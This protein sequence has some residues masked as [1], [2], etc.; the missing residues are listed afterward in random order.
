M[1]TK[2]V[3]CQKSGTIFIICLCLYIGLSC[4]QHEVK[5]YCIMQAILKFPNLAQ[6]TL[7]FQPTCRW[8]YR[9]STHTHHPTRDN[10]RI[11][12]EI[13]SVHKKTTISL[14]VVTEEEST[15]NLS[16]LLPPTMNL[17]SSGWLKLNKNRSMLP[18]TE[19]LPHPSESQPLHPA[20]VPKS[21]L[22][23]WSNGSRAQCEL[24]E[25]VW[26]K[27][28]EVHEPLMCFRS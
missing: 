5:C 2:W 21:S 14:S 27:P 12:T 7:L 25:N 20:Q 9:H 18:R 16:C 26:S 11:I 15:M 19:V 4:L 3:T 6:A 8:D 17:L 24:L 1:R 13:I 10:D 22:H 28:G 23:P